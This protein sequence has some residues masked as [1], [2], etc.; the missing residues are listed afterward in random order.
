MAKKVK[1]PRV[2][3]EPGQSPVLPA[4]R[5]VQGKRVAIGLSGGVDSAVAAA[6]LVE[7][8]YDVTG[9]HLECWSEPG[10]RAPQDRKDAL[11]V[12]MQLGIPFD[13][14]DFQKKY[15]E[16]VIE[17][18]YKEYEAGR[19]PNPDIMCNLEI[20]FGLFYNW[21]LKKGFDYVATGHYAQ[22]RGP[23]SRLLPIGFDIR[24]DDRRSI[25]Q[26]SSGFGYHLLRGVDEKKDQTYF[27]YR[28]RGEQLKKILFPVGNLM[29]KQVREEAK[30]RGL[31]VADKKDSVGVCFIGDINVQEFLRR[32]IRERRGDVVME[33]PHFA[34]ATSRRLPTR[35]FRDSVA[36]RGDKRDGKSVS[37]LSRSASDY[38]VV[39]E[40]KGVW[41]YTVGQRA[42]IKIKMSKAL[43]KKLGLNPT[44]LPPLYVVSKDVAQ[45]RLIVGVHKEALRSEFEVG[46]IHWIGD[47]SKVKSPSG[48]GQRQ[49]SKVK[50]RIRHGGALIPAKLVIHDSK[51][52]IHLKEAQRGVAPGQSAV[53]YRGEEC[54]GGGVI[55]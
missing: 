31:H 17:Y 3:R 7:Q 33:I 47:K 34:T 8:G 36:S 25:Y 1:K 23:H 41:F 26:Y 32:R 27:L 20:K 21:A 51:F 9:V 46:D 14:L 15:Q 22:I 19:T 28:L 24:S 4:D 53:F 12:A 45:N 35:P 44:N 2:A 42:G 50:V 54:L 55:S 43:G 13:V 37:H 49:K 5:S 39:G 16:K 11:E 48:P 52:I 40:H 38:V 29:K 18:F 10:C 6:L 30:K